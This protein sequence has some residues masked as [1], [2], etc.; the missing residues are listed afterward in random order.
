MLGYLTKHTRSLKTQ[1]SLKQI[2][3]QLG[4]EA[5]GFSSSAKQ[6]PRGESKRVPVLLFA[7]MGE[8]FSVEIVIRKE[9]N[10]IGIAK[11]IAQAG[12]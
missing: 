1:F 4:S 8:L 9:Y 5:L 10:C 7:R 6:A 3:Y 12:F 11:E 2:Y